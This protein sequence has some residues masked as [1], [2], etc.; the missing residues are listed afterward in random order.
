MRKATWLCVAFCAAWSTIQPGFTET[1]SKG[2]ISGRVVTAN[3]E[4]VRRATVVIEEVKYADGSSETVADTTTG[5]NGEFS[6]SDLA[7][8]RYRLEAEKSGYV[9]GRYPETK[10]LVRLIPG[11]NIDNVTLRLVAVSVVSGS[12]LDRNGEPLSKA[13]IRL[14]QYK[15]YPGGRRLTVAHEAISDERGQYRIGD[16]NPGRYYVVASYHSRI[17]DA[18]CPPVYYPDVA[19]FDDADP[20]RLAP[21]DEAPIEFVLISGKPVH[22]RGS[23]SGG[24][25]AVHVSLIPRGGIPY[26]QPLSVDIAPDGSFQFKGVL[27]GDYTVLATSQSADEMLE[28]RTRVTVGDHDLDGLSVQIKDRKA[29][30]QLWVSV[31]PSSDSTQDV[32]I[33]LHRPIA[34]NEDNIIVAEDDLAADGQEISTRSGNPIELPYPGPF[35]V[36]AEKLPAGNAY[37]DRA[38]FKEQYAEQGMPPKEQ[39]EIHVNS[40]GSS[41]EGLVVDST[42]RPLPGALVVAVPEHARNS[43]VDQS[44]TST[45]DQYGQFALHGLAPAKYEIYAWEDIVEGAYYDPDFL[46]D[47]SGSALGIDISSD[48]HYQVKLHAASTAPE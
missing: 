19:S 7:P 29:H 24:V 1:P 38:D 46:A 33:T 9:A 12:V 4:P 27:P 21:S 36:S 25:G 23:V 35:M 47:Y 26:A 3:G 28:G 10:A 34:S 44:R 18:V 40:H 13:V 37:I 11:D 16:L 43:G 2:A 41:V 14:L 32:V 15:Y 20:I 42:D 30:R 6:F 22:V 39:L 17:S 31:A 5:N 8:A 45:A 48:N